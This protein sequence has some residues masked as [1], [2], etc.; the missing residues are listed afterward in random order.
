MPADLIYEDFL[1]KHG[2]TFGVPEEN[3]EQ[4]EFERQLT[5]WKNLPQG[6]KVS[7]ESD[8]MADEAGVI[9]MLNEAEFQDGIEKKPMLYSKKC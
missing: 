9:A 4:T 7:A 6:I 8:F 1:S 2:V 3:S 5:E